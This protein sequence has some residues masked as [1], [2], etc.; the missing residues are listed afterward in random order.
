MGGRHSIKTGCYSEKKV[1]KIFLWYPIMAFV[2]V[3]SIIPILWVIMSSFKTSNEIISSALSLPHSFSFENYLEA[4]RISKIQNYFIN[5]I[6]ISI[7]ATI[8]GVLLFSM[9]AYAV[10][11]F[12]FR[13][14]NLLY[15][16]IVSTVLVP[17]IS[18]IQPLYK[19][20]HWLGLY[21]TRMGLILVYA[22]G[23]VA[24]VTFVM[25]VSFENLPKEMEESAYI[26]GAGFFSTYTRIM[27]PVSKG[28]L[29][30]AAVLVFLPSWN[31]FFYALMLM[32]SQ[33]KRTV[34]IALLYFVG[35]FTYNYSALFAAVTLVIV[36]SI[37]IYLVLQ[38]QVTSS[39]VSGAV[40]G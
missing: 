32:S 36:P 29:T 33:S 10:A 27:L 18:L 17:G 1:L 3:I 13:G 19:L 31:D 2:V 28:G 25:K 15:I 23:G 22:C 34:P 30:T 40:K 5:S 20:L 37:V 9:G 39:L 6:V 8:I 11:R 16:L 35:I 24:V 21:D 4:F 26:E 38:E 7:S 12:E 14:R